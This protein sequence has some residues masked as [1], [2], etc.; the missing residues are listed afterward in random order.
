[1]AS[2]SCCSRSAADAGVGGSDAASWLHCRIISSR[3]NV[4]D[5]S[6]IPSA[7]N[8]VSARRRNISRV[9]SV[10][11]SR[12]GG[13]TTGS[14]TSAV[15]T[16]RRALAALIGARRTA[17]DPGECSLCSATTPRVESIP[18]S[19]RTASR[20]TGTRAKLWFPL[21]V[22]TSTSRAPSACF[23][24]NQASVRLTASAAVGNDARRFNVPVCPKRS[25]SSACCSERRITSRQRSAARRTWPS[26]FSSGGVLSTAASVGAMSTTRANSSYF[27]AL[28]GS[29]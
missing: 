22:T 5:G 23:I 16:S 12:V 19:R 15:V 29:P 18:R 9:S 8:A 1:M 10:R 20:T 24:R 3:T 4:A 13:A 14:A 21:P 17:N 11:P 25:S 27:P 26:S 28:N 6:R 2:R 7:R